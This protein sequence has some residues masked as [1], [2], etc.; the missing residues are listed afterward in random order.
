M[1][2]TPPYEVTEEMLEL[3][4]EIM[5]LIGGISSVD[6]L[7]KLPRLRR[8]S[9]I[10]SIHSSLAIEN[11]TLT[12]E[13]VSAILD[14]KKVIGPPDEII[15]AEN[16]IVAYKELEN[17]DPFDL[18]EL[19]RIHNLMMNRLLSD[20]GQ[21]RSKG[22]GVFEDGGKVV[23][24]APPHGRVHGLMSDLFLWLKS[25]KVHSLIKSSVFHYELEFIHPFSD[26]NGRMGR[27]WQTAILANWKPIFLWIPVEGIIKE[28]QQGYYNAIAESTKLG[29]CNPF[30]LFMLH[31]ILQAVRD[32]VSGV[33]AH[34][35]HIDSKVRSLLEV[36][37]DFQL[38]A[39][40]IMDKLGLKSRNSFRDNYL[41]PALDAGVIAL[42][43]P[44]KPTSRNQKYF[45]K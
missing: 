20:A 25:T 23:Y 9:R 4:S 38:T 3:V 30:I 35:N 32:I 31:A 19:L 21:L 14:G 22:V 40:E 45:R 13:Q 37:S 15:E 24:M 17:A 26:G 39:Q 33:R 6:N 5:E 41:N 10:R 7:N 28:R 29:S 16:A 42:T 27:I 44:E 8:S 11:N 36:L 1:G 18:T 2:Y 12:Y 34:I 43:E